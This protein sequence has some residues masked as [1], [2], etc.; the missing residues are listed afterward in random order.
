MPQDINVL[1]FW[2][3]LLSAKYSFLFYFIGISRLQQ[4][5]AGNLSGNLT[6]LIVFYWVHIA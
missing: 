1:D 3:V 4:L 5:I 2:S 6:V